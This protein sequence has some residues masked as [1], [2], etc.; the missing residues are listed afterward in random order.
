MRSKN[1]LLTGCD[2]R[3]E[4]DKE[5]EMPCGILL[6]QRKDI[7]EKQKQKQGFEYGF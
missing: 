2:F 1:F 7:G 6:E 5:T 3:L 4:K